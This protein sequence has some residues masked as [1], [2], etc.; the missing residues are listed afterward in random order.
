[1][2]SDETRVLVPGPRPV[3]IREIQ[4]INR[5][6]E[7][8][9]LREAA[10]RAIRGEGGVVFLHGEAG[11]GKTRL[12]RELSIYARSQGMQV[13]SGRCPA[14]FRMDGV[15][16]YV[17][18]EEV[19]K[20]Y[21]ETC[22]P[23]QLYR[24]VGSYPVE[25]SKLVPQLKQKLSTIPQS[26]PLSPE[27]SRDRLFE[28][29]TQFVTNIAEEKPLLVILDDLQWTDQSSL[30]LLHYLA[31]GIYNDSLLVLGAYRE[32]YIDDQHPLSP[33]LAELN[34]ERL[35]QLVPL[36]RLSLDEVLEMIKRMLEQDEVA[37][38]F[39]QLV[40]EKTR[41]NPF[42]VEEVIRS[43]KEDETIHREG[44]KWK[45]KRVSE[46]R[47]PKTIKSVLKKRIS[48]LDK[49]AQNV[50]TQ[51]SFIGKDFV[52][53]ALSK[54][55]GT[56]EDALLEIIEKMLKT[57][58]IQEREVRGEPVYS[59]ADILV[60]D[61]VYDEISLLRRKRLHGIVGRALEEIYANETDKHLGELALHFLESG[62]KNKALDYFLKA[63][64]KAAKVFA[65]NE[66]ASYLESALT[67]HE[68]G[69]SSPSEIAPILEKIGDIKTV[70]GEHEET[71]KYWNKALSQWKQTQE[72]GNVARLHRKFANIYWEELG[73]QED[74]RQHH[75]EALR[76]LET[77]SESSEL[78]SLYEDLAHMSYKDGDLSEALSWGK[79]A[80]D[81]AEKL[82]NYEVIASSYV[83]LGT[84]FQYIGKRK[85]GIECLNKGLRIALDNNLVETALRAF[86]NI[87][88]AY[89]TEEYEKG[90]EILKKGYDLAK[91]AGHVG[92]QS[93]IGNSLS[94]AYLGMGDT[95]KA[96]SLTEDSAI[97]DRKAANIRNLAYSLLAR[98]VIY[99]ALGEWEKS[100]QYF[101]KAQ[102]A[103]QKSDDFFLA[104]GCNGTIGW[105]NYEKGEFK[106]AR[107]YLEKWYKAL[108]K[109][110]AKPMKIEYSPFLIWTYVELGDFRKAEVLY[111]KLQEYAIRSKS[112]WLTIIAE[113]TRAKQLCAQKKWEESIN[114][115]KKAFELLKALGTRK[116][117]VH[118]FA[119][120]GLYEFAQVYLDRNHAGD[121]EKARDLLIEALEIF[122]RMGAK[123][124]IEK[125]KQKLNLTG[126]TPETSLSR[127][128]PTQVLPTNIK[129]GYEDLDRLL[130]GGIPA[131]YSIVLT[132]PSCDERDMLVKSFLET[133]AREEEATFH[134]VARPS[135]TNKLAETHKSNFYLFMCNPEANAIV[136]SLPNVFKLKGIENL[137]DLNIALASAFRKLPQHPLKPRR[138]CIEILSDVLLQH[139]TVQTRRWL[140][141]LI[142][143]LKS[144]G[145]TTLAVM[146]PG[147]HSP[148]EVRGVLDLFEGEINIYEKQTA[149]G[150][151]KLLRIRK[152]INQEYSKNE[153]HFQA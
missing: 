75:N 100:I 125:T 96:L 121:A 74:A 24:V 148:Q 13:L 44:N 88:T 105:S 115:F 93:W 71:L 140:N 136:E 65:N 113:T 45:I 134:I 89:E 43:L 41:G 22:T 76:I 103:A 53:G 128:M 55:T 1:M 63:G 87:A 138:A 2:S 82:N 73:S 46:I 42:F 122:E 14:L 94:G 137:N 77:E 52:F 90:F 59:F 124:W 10:D 28:A 114:H 12:A 70:V 111:E 92:M 39:C 112:K 81:L 56:E 151:E 51:A 32:T 72:K 144:K 33:V 57:G 25:V 47:F 6:D 61:V 126:I 142:P 152:M 37:K 127:P 98:G 69:G 132:S 146:D 120:Y 97:L 48:R 8:Q 67:I 9:V 80:L 104:N 60:R 4:L 153:L 139:H 23:E 3:P 109:V 35:L 18:W 79:K 86:N 17:L 20:D 101:L 19:I 16:P 143:R 36:K 30:L 7:M 95:M 106:K 15:P 130:P 141:A 68:E 131:T 117:H 102:D 118:A 83:T 129:L 78:A 50:L 31:R 11:I 38:D 21:L 85:K 64:E 29:V 107:E 27:H 62:E 58:L 145:F 99:Q 116:W 135:G 34:R 40:F 108:D 149:R 150:F 49:T 66:A 133:G 54:V 84:T 26:F 147:M 5:T 123:K 119:R 110:G 91:K